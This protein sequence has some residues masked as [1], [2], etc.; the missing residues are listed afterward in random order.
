M[1]V[2]IDLDD[3][4]KSDREYSGKHCEKIVKAIRRRLKEDGA[5]LPKIDELME[6][7]ESVSSGKNEYTLKFYIGVNPPDQLGFNLL[8]KA[9]EVTNEELEGMVVVHNWSGWKPYGSN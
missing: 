6:E 8:E 9:V 5:P 7:R 2:K 1:K 4:T 3:E